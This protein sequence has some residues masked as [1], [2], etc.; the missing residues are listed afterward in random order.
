MAK[1]KIIRRKKERL[2][3][4]I[5]ATCRP[6]IQAAF[7]IQ[8]EKEKRDKSDLYR[9]ALTLYLD[10]HSVPTPTPAQ[11]AEHFGPEWVKKN[12]YQIGGDNE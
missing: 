3:G 9:D 1:R 7:E 2:I 10:K 11:V 4:R 6:E 5:T 8:A 12:E